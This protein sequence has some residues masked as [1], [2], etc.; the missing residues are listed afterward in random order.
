M[1]HHNDERPLIP[2]YPRHRGLFSKKYAQTRDAHITARER[3]F[4]PCRKGN[5]QSRPGR[6]PEESGDVGNDFPAQP[7]IPTHSATDDIPGLRDVCEKAFF[8]M[9]PPPGIKTIRSH[10]EQGVTNRFY[11]VFISTMPGTEI[12]NACRRHKLQTKNIIIGVS[13]A[14]Y[15]Y[16]YSKYDYDTALS[17]R[18]GAVS[19]DFDADD[20]R[21]RSPGNIVRGHGPGPHAATVRARTRPAYDPPYRLSAGNGRTLMI[22]GSRD[23]SS[24][25][26]VNHLL[27]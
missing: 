25:E 3:E 16:I 23:V 7:E 10:K 21:I 26:N 20:D 4:L 12:M 13:G 24:W 2:L 18:P 22:L 15:R 6:R 9:K 1:R 5:A 17:A 19:A 14:G 27:L 11:A 8:E